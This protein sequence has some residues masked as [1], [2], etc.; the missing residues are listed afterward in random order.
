MRCVIIGENKL[1]IWGLSAR[2]R[3]EKLARAN[4]LSLGG[5][6]SSHLEDGVILLDA[7][8]VFDEH[9]LSYLKGLN[10]T[11]IID[12]QGLPLACIT[13]DPDLVNKSID[14]QKIAMAPGIKTQEAATMPSIF[15][16]KQL[17]SGVPFI[18][19]LETATVKAVEKKLYHST[20]KGVTDLCTKYFW[21][22][23]AF[24]ITHFLANKRVKPNMVT[25]ISLI[26]CI[27]A[28]VLI[29]NNY[30]GLGICSAWIMMIL[31][32]VDGKLARL[33]ITSSRIG[34][35]FDH[36]MD[37]I[38]P[39]FWYWA[40]GEALNRFYDVDLTRVLA[41]FYCLLTLYILGR[42]SE[43]LFSLFIKVE[44]FVWRTFDSRF[45][46]ILARRNTNFLILTISYISGA[47][48]IGYQAI[49]W[50]SILSVLVQ[51]GRLGQAWYLKQF[52]LPLKLD[53]I[54]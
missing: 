18:Q 31:D 38:H 52:K 47:P 3:I 46:L 16:R 28:P 23:L 36:G 35:V 6:P 14:E 4:K 41:I 26:F 1:V 33:T 48:G 13:T 34:D 24:Y 37:L 20:Y 49:C 9:F 22:H 27:L 30:W 21:Y 42:L 40:W 5:K 44:M 2:E 39:P 43:L 19:K 11:V 32:T 51:W 10:N 45:R 54:S 25:F 15:F 29:S 50:W 17:K 7:S 53:Y 12:E 8:T